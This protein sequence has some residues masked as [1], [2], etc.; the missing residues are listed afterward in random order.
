MVVVVAACKA[1]P[2][3][4]PALSNVVRRAVPAEPCSVA[5]LLRDAT[6]HEPLAGA[7]VVLD[8][9]RTQNE[10]AISD[11]DGRFSIRS[12]GT[13]TMMTVYYDDTTWQR[14]LAGG[15]CGRSGEVAISIRPHRGPI[16][17]W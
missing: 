9:A 11:E 17:V 7:T 12:I 16:I 14:P 3:A 15:G 4:P 13:Q 8:G 6:T 2:P 5:G 1:A 10:V